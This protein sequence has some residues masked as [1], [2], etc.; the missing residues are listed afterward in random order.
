MLSLDDIKSD[1]GALIKPGGI[2]KRIIVAVALLLVVSFTLLGAILSVMIY[3]TE[4]KELVTLQHEIAGFAVNEMR[5]DIHEL[6]ALLGLAAENYE[7]ARRNGIS[8]AGFLNQILMAEHIKHHNIVEELSFIGKDGREKE[9]VSRMT[10]YDATGLRDLSQSDEFTVPQKSG[11]TYFGPV[12]FASGTFVPCMTMSI[13]IKDIR[14]N[15]LQA[16]LMAKIRL[17]KVWEN[18]VERS[19]GK[20]GIVFITDDRGKVLAHPDPSEIY[21]NT[22][23]TPRSPE[24]VQKGLDGSEAMVVSRKVDLGN[25][26]FIVYATVPFTEVIAL[27]RSALFAVAIFFV[28]FLTLSI[29]LSLVALGR[30]IRPV[31]ALADS[32]RRIT[33]GELTATVTVGDKDEIGD[34]STALSIMTTRLMDTIHSLEQRNEL[35][36]NVLNA[37]THPFYV[38][39]ANDYTIQLAN[40]AAQF[41]RETGKTT[42]YAL[43]HN[44]GRPCAEDEHPCVI[45]EIRRTGKTVSVEHVHRGEN[46]DLRFY[47]VHGYPIYDMDGNI[48]QVIEYN[49]DITERRKAEQKL[50]LSEQRNRIITSTARDAII[51]IDEDGRILFWNPAAEKIFGYAEE[52]MLGTE[53]HSILVPESYREKYQKGM[54]KFR[55]TGAGTAVGQTTEMSARRKDGTEFPVALSLSAFQMANRW[56]AVGIVRDITQR[57]L[58]EKRIL[59]SLEEKELLLQEIHHRVKNNLQII[60]SLLDLQLEYVGE[61]EPGEIFSEIKNRVKSMALVHEK[62][63][64]AKDLSKVDFHDYLVTLIDNLY[65][66]YTVSIARIALK[67]EVEDIS[68]G[69]DTAIPCGLIVNELITNSLKYAFP[70]ERSG[71]LQVM[72]RRSGRDDRGEAVYELIVGDDGIGIPQGVDLKGATTLGLYLVT[73]LV[74]H[75][76]RGSIDLK[77]EQGTVFTIHFKEVRYKKRL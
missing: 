25:R 34:L 12:T 52:E 42:C 31:E 74:M 71:Q 69:I 65:R 22:Y 48:V 40:P 4:K 32:A 57:K 76:L 17:N 24:G 53:L 49:I 30:M 64:H 6:E 43:T 11:E 62:L 38:I 73:T 72:L 18:A 50:L 67:M 20:A 63:Y 29:F 26:T 41:H 10:V 77:R 15:T 39:D 35:V 37:L 9:R 16:V 23:Y 68:L 36:N 45:E 60:S 44:S 27:S 14:G 1:I 8:D 46:G 3:L 19:F 21:R 33:A 56:H 70:G 51:M 59:A 66:S 7:W 2:R 58:A 13:P 55:E 28:G 75:Q 5:W 54:A 47:E 61:R